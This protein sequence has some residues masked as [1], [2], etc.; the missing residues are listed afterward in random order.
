MVENCYI[1]Y[2]C[3][4]S[5]DPIVS[6]YSGLSAHSSSFVTIETD[7]PSVS[8]DTCYYVL[9]IG[10]VDCDPTYNVTGATSG[11]S[12]QC[13]CYLIKSVSA[14]TD[15]TYVN[16]D[17]EIVVDTMVD[18]VTY[19]ICSKVYPQFDN[20]TPIPIKLTDICVDGGCPS[21]I[22]TVKPANECDVI[23]IFP[24]GVTCSVLQPTSDLTFDGAATLIITGGT[25]P[26]TVAWDSGSFAPAITNLGIGEYKATVTDYYN[27]FTVLTNCILTAETTTFSG[28][29]FVVSGLVEDN[30]SYI[31]TESSGLKNGKPYYKLQNG[32]TILGYVFWSQAQGLWI[33]CESLDCQGSFYQSLN[34]S[35]YLY[36]SGDTWNTSGT[37][38][39]YIEESY[40][41]NCVLPFIPK[42]GSSL[43]V[44]LVNRSKDPDQP[45]TVT[46]V[47]MNPSVDI[48]GQMSWTSSTGQYVIY[49]N[50]GST[51]SQWTFTG[52]SNPSVLIVSND[53]SDPPIS[54]WQVLGAPEISSF[55][56]VEGTCS[57]AY[58]ISVNAVVN[59]SSCNTNSGSITV[60][61]NGGQAPYQYSINAG[62]TYQ[63]S[64]IFNGLS[65]G[66]YTVFVQDTNSTVGTL[67]G[68]TI[69][70]TTLPT[71]YNLTLN[72]DYSTGL[73]SITTP[74]LPAGVTI[75][76][77]LVHSSTFSYYPTTLSPLPTYNN[78]TTIT[79]IGTMT[80]LNT[81]SNTY[82]LGGPCTAGGAINVTQQ[83]RT[84]QN[85]IT[86]TSNQIINGSIT[87]SVIN[88]PTGPC[89]SASGYYQL[90]ITNNVIENC[91]C[92]NLNVIN[93]TPPGPVVI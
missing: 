25:P 26:Y 35:G 32:T 80:L 30:L 33:F 81:N 22:P 36:P 39:Y 14:T 1:L 55:S 84:F 53:P 48:N 68:N 93:S 8:G 92:C 51:P 73:F 21:S 41:G 38:S 7:D 13:F 19:N 3:D 64:P 12:C 29:C 82:A 27:D 43:C 40:P 6:N 74:T 71:T 59:N 72:V 4:G 28:I 63:A 18:G 75:T 83:T 79:G 90:L 45:D 34:N 91:D 10:V 78:I 76:F 52:Y 58:T 20:Q 50:T 77:D 60:V 44:T 31:S 57:S 5:Y 2:S 54:N 86:M 67:I 62:F 70:G 66:N 49:W 23:T 56:V 61:A 42:S 11:C 17:N 9:D 47:D 65:P 24:M 46:N 16:C 69:V 89:E 87:N 37:T 88:N 15:V 85:T